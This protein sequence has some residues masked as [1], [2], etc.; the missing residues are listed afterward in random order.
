MTSS[1][2]EP[3]ATDLATLEVRFR[4]VEEKVQRVIRLSTLRQ[5][6]QA[7]DALEAA[8]AAEDAVTVGQVLSWAERVLQ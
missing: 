8:K 1:A 3:G 2:Q 4:S 5:F 7:R 6:A